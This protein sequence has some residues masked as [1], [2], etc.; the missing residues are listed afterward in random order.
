MQGIAFMLVATNIQNL[1][2]MYEFCCIFER[3][4]MQECHKNLRKDDGV[5]KKMRSAF[6]PVAINRRRKA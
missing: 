3:M 2:R 5:K 4:Y 1:L 6:L